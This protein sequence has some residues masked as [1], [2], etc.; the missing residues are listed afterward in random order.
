MN[1]SRGVYLPFFF[2]KGRWENQP[3]APKLIESER[4]GKFSV[5]NFNTTVVRVAVAL[6]NLNGCFGHWV[7]ARG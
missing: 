5:A 3:K 6:V 7:E 2:K 1:L 4:W